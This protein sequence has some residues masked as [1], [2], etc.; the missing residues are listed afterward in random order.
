MRKTYFFKRIYGLNS[1][2]LTKRQKEVYMRKKQTY[3]T[4]EERENCQ[5]VVNAFAEL[6]ENTVFP[7]SF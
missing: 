6:F 7:E 2:Q 5:K 1:L 3:I 4:D